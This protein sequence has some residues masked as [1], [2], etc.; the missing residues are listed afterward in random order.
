MTKEWRGLMAEEMLVTPSGVFE[1][2]IRCKEQ[3]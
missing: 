3:Y 1:G 2:A